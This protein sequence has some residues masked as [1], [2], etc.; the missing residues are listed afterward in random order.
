MSSFER[1][2]S[3][4]EGLPQLK[5]CLSVRPN[6]VGGTCLVPSKAREP[7]LGALTSLAPTGLGA[8]AGVMH[9]EHGVEVLPEHQP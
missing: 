3:G 6:P 5:G 1:N 8:S 2:E 9:E 7:G 4:V